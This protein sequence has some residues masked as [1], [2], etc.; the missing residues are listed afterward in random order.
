MVGHVDHGKSTLLGRLFY[1]TGSMPQGKVEAI[2]AMCKRRGVPFEWAFL[3]DALRAERDQNITIDMSHIWFKTATRPYVMI[4]A[5]GHREF[6]KNM[7]T[8]AAS[9]SAAILVIAADEGVREQSRRHG[10]ML[11]L[12]GIRQVA[13]VINKMDLV[14]FSQARFREIETEYRRFLSEI[15][16]EPKIFIPVSAR[17]GNNIVE[18]S[19]SLGWFDGPSLVQVLDSFD[20]PATLQEIALRLPVQ[21]VYRFDHRRIIAGRVERGEVK[22]GDELTFY[23]SGRSSKVATVEA[24]GRDATRATA[25][26]T[27]GITLTDQ[28]FVERG[29]VA[30][31][32]GDPPPGLARR[33]TA[34]IFWLGKRPLAQGS[35]YKIKLVTQELSCRVVEVSDVVDASTLETKAARDVL[36]RD[37]VAR[38]VFETDRPLVVD[39]Y[40]DFVSTGRFVL[41]DGYD[42]AGGGIV[43]GFDAKSPQTVRGPVDTETRWRL[44]GQ[45]GL[46]VQL[47]GDSEQIDEIDRMLLESGLRTAR[48]SAEHAPALKDAG[49][50]AIVESSSDVV[51]ALKTM[52]TLEIVTSIRRLILS[53]REYL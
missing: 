28:L 32:T 13:V 49:I 26:E 48:T 42:V 27:V 33:V 35:V 2:E 6:L 9:A 1:E 34:N 25:G 15:G 24:W 22:A 20:A 51:F 11:S 38:V 5:P 8:G 53:A 10:Y 46:I 37:D 18:P 43:V 39:L 7:I 14:D 21:D 4:D 23:P 50:V 40:A 47:V 29:Q 41:V 12:L 44:G 52:S 16:L 3:M 17:H 19:E 31:R 45:P 36:D 30:V